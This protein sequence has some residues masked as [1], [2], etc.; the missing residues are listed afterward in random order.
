[1]QTLF[2]WDAHGSA[3]AAM[4]QQVLEQGSPD[5]AVRRQALEMAEGAWN[6]RQTIDAQL[7]RLA[8]QWPPRR[9][10][11]VD[12]NILRVAVWELGNSQTPPKVVLDEAIEMAKIFSTEQ[13]AAFVNGVLDAVLREHMALISAEPAPQTTSDL[14][15]PTPIT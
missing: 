13:S 7:E 6:Q 4:A 2:A 5:A 15:P 14:P 1:M 11:S 9:Q 3:D 8:P 12:R 10:P